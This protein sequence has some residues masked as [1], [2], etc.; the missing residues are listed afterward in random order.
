MIFYYKQYHI[1][2]GFFIIGILLSIY[3][4]A[5]SAEGYLLYTA[6]INGNLEKCKCGPNITRGIG[7]IKRFFSEFRKVYSQTIIID[8]GDNLINN[9]KIN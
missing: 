6:N 8:G 3:L 7:H 4:T 9:T 5:Y 1:S 2:P